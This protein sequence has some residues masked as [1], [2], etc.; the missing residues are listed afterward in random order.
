MKNVNTAICVIDLTKLGYGVIQGKG[1]RYF[2]TRKEAKEYA[3]EMVFIE[4]KHLTM[5]DA[6]SSEPRPVGRILLPHTSYPVFF[7][8]LTL[9][10]LPSGG[11]LQETSMIR[12]LL[13]RRM[14]SLR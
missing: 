3:C 7:T 12:G 1:L 10:L 9:R 13:L 5:N 11:C 8:S 14:N 6:K 2:A 4:I